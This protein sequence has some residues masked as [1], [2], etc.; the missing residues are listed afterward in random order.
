MLRFQ[1]PCPW[2]TKSKEIW[3]KLA[4]SLLVFSSLAII[5][6]FV[7]NNL[8][9]LF[10]LKVVIISLFTPLS[11]QKLIHH[12]FFKSTFK[13]VLAK[14]FLLQLQLSSQL[15]SEPIS[16]RRLKFCSMVV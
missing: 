12:R 5:G 4:F 7:T 13:M 15:Y 1:Y 6:G 14:Q 9:I 3:L 11:F 10:V 8:P 16:L 2:E